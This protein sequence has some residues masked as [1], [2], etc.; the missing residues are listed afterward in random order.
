MMIERNEMIKFSF[1]ILMNFQLGGSLIT[2][3]HI[4]TA[5]HCVHGPYVSKI[6]LTL[7]YWFA[8]IFH[9]IF[10]LK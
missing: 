8:S 4:L 1:L 9:L 3:K 6:L 5:G 7:A 2:S 10:F